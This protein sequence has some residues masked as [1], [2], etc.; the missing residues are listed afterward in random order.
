MILAP[1]LNLPPIRRMLLCLKNREHQMQESDEKRTPQETETL[2]R[3]VMKR[4]LQ[5]PPTPHAPKKKAA[6]RK[7]KS[8]RK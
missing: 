2:A 4:M 1:I 5:T 6:K 3:E 8:P 7:S